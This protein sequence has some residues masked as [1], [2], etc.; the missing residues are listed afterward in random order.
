LR[1][2]ILTLGGIRMA[3]RCN[4]KGGEKWDSRKEQKRRLFFN[5]RFINQHDGDIIFDRID[6]LALN[7]F[8][9]IPIRGQ[10]NSLL[11]QRANKDFQ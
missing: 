3:I 5:L 6:A 11:T 10:F 7:T 1:E 2:E 4:R 8:E 9:P